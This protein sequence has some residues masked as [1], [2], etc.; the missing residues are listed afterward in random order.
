MGEVVLHLEDALTKSGYVERSYF[1]V[2]GG[3]AVVTR[4]EQIH[5]DGSPFS[6]PDRWVSGDENGQSLTI[7]EY[8][9]RLFA[10]D[11]GYYR[12][13]VFILT[14]EAFG[15]QSRSITADEATRWLSEGLNVLPAD[16]VQRPLSEAHS[17][18]ALVYEFQ[19]PH[20]QNPRLLVPS[21]LGAQQHLVASGLYPLLLSNTNGGSR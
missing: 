2:P 9:R 10:A 3:I 19:K 18:T 6:G 11:E 14:D 21:S 8:L 17:C 1:L 15:S 7:S 20:G 16:L 12:I 5:P 4:L 13:V